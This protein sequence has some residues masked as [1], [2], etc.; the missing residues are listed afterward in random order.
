MIKSFSGDGYLKEEFIKLVKQFNIKNIVE[1]GTN[2]GFTTKEFAKMVEHVYTIESNKEYYIESK[3]NLKKLNNIKLYLGSSPSVLEH[4]LPSLKGRTLF[5]LDAH[6]G[7]YWPILDE[8]KEIAKIPNLSNSVIV[9]HDFYVPQ[10]NLG[11]DSYHYSKSPLELFIKR[12]ISVIGRLLNMKLI[13]KQKLDY[14]FIADSI[15]KINPEYKHHYNS[16]AEG[17]KRGVIF[18]CPY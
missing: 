9:I 16:K 13:E 1:T 4:M 14:N 11:F 7:D 5:F 17:N 8:L 3:K 12:G 15:H 10:S 2:K 18:I 6:W